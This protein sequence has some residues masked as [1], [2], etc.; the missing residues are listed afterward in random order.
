[1]GL[2]D[3]PTARGN[4]G[5]GH[6]TTQ[7]GPL[8]P[9]RLPCRRVFSGQFSDLGQHEYQTPSHSTFTPDAL[10]P[11]SGGPQVNDGAWRG[12]YPYRAGLTLPLG[13]RSW[14]ASE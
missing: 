13:A 1:M 3:P 10:P 8:D 2:Q 9:A 11:G 14:I 4:S 6:S 7:Q 12:L 5:S